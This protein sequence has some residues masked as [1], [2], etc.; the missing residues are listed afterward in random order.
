MNDAAGADFPVASHDASDVSPGSNDWMDP[1]MA[2][3]PGGACWL[4]MRWPCM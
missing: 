4:S 3:I 2:L 1:D